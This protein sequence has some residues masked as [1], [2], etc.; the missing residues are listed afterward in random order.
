MSKS[1]AA[2][3]FWRFPR[4]V[5]HRGGGVLAPENTLLAMQTGVKYGIPAVEFDVMLSRD[6]VPMVIHDEEVRRTIRNSEHI[7]KMFNELDAQ[8]LLTLDAGSFFDP[9]LSHIRIPLFEDVLNYC[10]DNHVFMNIEIKPATGF[11]MRTG[12]VVAEMT[13]RYYDRLAQA[14]V[15]PLFSSFSFDALKAAKEVAPHI[16]RGFLMHQS[17]DEVPNWKQIVSDLG[18]VSLNVNKDSLTEEHVNEIKAFGCGV[19]VYT[20]NDLV[21]AEKLLSWGVDCL[22]TDKIDTF[23]PLAAR[24]RP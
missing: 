3:T 9:S 2:L 23:S 18:A 6:K 22:C 7:G 16:P 21:E 4:V 15:A 1:H 20:V 17:L 19:F 10:L 8:E 14:G 24:L 11:E 12:I 5:S 13:A